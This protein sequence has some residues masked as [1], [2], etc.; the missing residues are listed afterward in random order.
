MHLYTRVQMHVCMSAHVRVWPCEHT[1]THILSKLRQGE[2]GREGEGG[3]ELVTRLKAWRKPLINTSWSLFLSPPQKMV[4]IPVTTSKDPRSSVG[5]PPPLPL[6]PICL[7]HHIFFISVPQYGFNFSYLG[8]RC[9][10]AVTVFGVS[11]DGKKAFFDTKLN[12]YWVNLVR[13]VIP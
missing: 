3:K 7:F 11:D 1:H 13:I 2:R 4:P 5:P 8:F 9:P 10:W 6:P 12:T